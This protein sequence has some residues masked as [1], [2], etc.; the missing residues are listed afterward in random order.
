MKAI[1][2][3]DG[4]RLVVSVWIVTDNEAEANIDLP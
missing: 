4:I 3:L 1:G 2:P